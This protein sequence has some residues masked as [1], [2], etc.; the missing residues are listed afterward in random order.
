V[1][2]ELALYCLTFTSYRFVDLAQLGTPSFGA[3]FA[4]PVGINS[5]A[6]MAIPRSLLMP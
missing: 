5:A 6:T 1:N 4:T 2:F 3:A